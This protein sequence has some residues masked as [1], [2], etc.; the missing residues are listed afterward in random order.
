VLTVY[1]HRVHYTLAGILLSVGAPLGLLLLRTLVFA[2]HSPALIQAEIASNW[3]VY[4]Y[5]SAT[6]MVAFGLFGYVLGQQTDTLQLQS[7]TDVLTGLYNR[8]G[9]TAHLKQEYSRLRRYGAPL[10]LLLIDVDELKRINDGQGHA[11]GDE[12]IRRFGAAIKATSRDT[13][14]GGRWGGD[15]FLIIAPSTAG[16]E[17]RTLAERLRFAIAR[18][19]LGG[20]PAATASVGVATL[21]PGAG[22]VESPETL[23]QAADSALHQAKATGRNQVR[24]A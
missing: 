2:L 9:L 15:E 19:E 14:I 7:T 17:A 13:D 20:Q 5:V 21:D 11:A 8:R 4:L 6:T 22:P 3:L 24:V 18:L 23:L 12:V 10:S 16:V 1:R